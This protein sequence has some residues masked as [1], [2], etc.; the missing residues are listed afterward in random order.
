MAKHRNE[1]INQQSRWYAV[2]VRGNQE[3]LTRELLEARG[4][5][6]FLPTYVTVRQWSDRRKR[7][8]RPLFTGYV[9][10]QAH[11]AERVN[12]LTL[13][14]VLRIV[15]TG[16]TPIPIDPD[17][18]AA[19]ESV[20]RADLSREPCDELTVGQ[21]VLVVDGPLAGHRGRLDCSRGKHRFLVSISL[22]ERSVAVEV[23]VSSLRPLEPGKLPPDRQAAA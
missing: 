19:L 8:E 9:F 11:H 7:I 6:T 22:I 5:K 23:P 12:I 4:Y 1:E 21:R 14:P 2:Q 13:Q 15:G 10:S 3:H 18:F 20:V 17:E 16:H